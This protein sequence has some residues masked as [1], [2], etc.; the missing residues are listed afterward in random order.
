MHPAAL[1][2]LCSCARVS[3]KGL[4]GQ[5]G[6]CATTA[7][8]RRERFIVLRAPA[9]IWIVRVARSPP[10]GLVQL[11]RRK[12]LAGRWRGCSDSD[13]GHQGR[14]RVT[15]RGMPAA[16]NDPVQ[17]QNR[18][19]DWQQQQQAS[20]QTDAGPGTQ[21]NNRVRASDDQRPA[22]IGGAVRGSGKLGGDVWMDPQ[23]FQTRA[24]RA[25]NYCSVQTA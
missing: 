16:R 6:M 23:D 7:M 21:S 15:T 9:R 8:W 2:L 19:L 18:R 20:H 1:G 10:G 5:V 22:A 13:R 14:K 4:V 25:V 24:A 3:C 12:T 11:R 17:P